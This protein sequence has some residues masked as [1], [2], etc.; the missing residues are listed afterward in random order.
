[1]SAYFVLAYVSIVR[2]FS[3]SREL[4]TGGGKTTHQGDVRKGRKI[5]VYSDRFKGCVRLRKRGSK[6]LLRFFFASAVVP[7]AGNLRN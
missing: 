6:C 3:L 5:Q 4:H 2:R 1:V 7:A